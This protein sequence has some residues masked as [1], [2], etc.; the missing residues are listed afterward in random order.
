[1][2]FGPAMGALSTGAGLLTTTALTGAAVSQADKML[3]AKKAR[4]R[5]KA[6]A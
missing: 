5:K 1:M 2:G 3:R 6:I 4:A